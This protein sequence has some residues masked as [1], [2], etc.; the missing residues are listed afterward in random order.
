MA[1]SYDALV[2]MLEA[3]EH[4]LKLLD[5]YTEVPQTPAMDE[6]AVKIMVELLSTLAL[7]TKELKQGR[8][9]ESVPAD[10]LDNSTQRRGIRTRDFCRRQAY[11]SSPAEVRSAHP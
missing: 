3:I 1:D 7:A 6:L 8:S 11:R 2:N 4:F 5:I 10:I 9:S